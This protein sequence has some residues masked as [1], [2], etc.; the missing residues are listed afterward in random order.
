MK[1]LNL[2]YSLV[3]YFLEQNSSESTVTRGTVKQIMDSWTL[4]TGYP[5]I[6]IERTS[7]GQK[8]IVTQV[9]KNVFLSAFLE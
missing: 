4:Q 9:V 5:V 1:Q 2:L 8:T 7:S 6:K 3:L